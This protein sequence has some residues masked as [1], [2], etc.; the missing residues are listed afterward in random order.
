VL[1]GFAVVA[2]EFILM[3]GDTPKIGGIQNVAS[4]EKIDAG[5]ATPSTRL[6]RGDP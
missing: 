6:L 5:R 3:R 1:V 2:V 4:L